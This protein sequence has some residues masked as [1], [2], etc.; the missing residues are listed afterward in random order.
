MW[1]EF[2]FPLLCAMGQFLKK[3]VAAKRYKG[4]YQNPLNH[5]KQAPKIHWGRALLNF[6]QQ[7]FKALTRPAKHLAHTLDRSSTNDGCY[8]YYLFLSYNLILLPKPD[9]PQAFPTHPRASA[10]ILALISSHPDY[11]QLLIT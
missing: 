3:F 4:F 2:P 1:S 8:Y 9:S 11:S 10:V 6:S 5:S 7:E